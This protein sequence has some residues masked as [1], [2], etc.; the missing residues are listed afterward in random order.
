[1]LLACSLC[2][3]FIF[4]CYLISESNITVYISNQGSYTGF[5]YSQQF[6][7]ILRL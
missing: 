7:F 5:T 1:M 3:R 2:D 6:N 4:C